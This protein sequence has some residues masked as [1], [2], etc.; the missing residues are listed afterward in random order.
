MGKFLLYIFKIII[1]TFFVA[2]FIQFLAD[3][4]LKKMDDSIYSD[5]NKILGGNINSDLVILGSSR[6]YVSY[7]PIIIENTT[8][9]TS[10]NLSINAGS[11]NLQN[12]KFES[13]L[14]KNR[15]PKVIIQN[16]DLTHFSKSNN[17]PEEFQFLPYLDNKNLTQKL[18]EINSDYSWNH[19]IPLYKYNNYKSFLVK[20]LVSLVGKDY[21][22]LPTNKGFAPKNPLFKKDEHNL[23]RLRAMSLDTSNI[24]SYKEKLAIS[25]E[26][27]HRYNTD[28][29]KIFLV[30][31]P[32]Y[33][34]RLDIIAPI[35]TPVKEDII[36]IVS[37]MPGVYF[38]DFSEDPINLDQK[39]FYDTFHL[40]E[41]GALL[42]TS[43][44][45]KEVD[46]ILKN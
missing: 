23:R 16:I 18:S 37:A 38:L 9:L 43:K 39:Y 3:L 13:Y 30:W 2:L 11:Y 12:L 4:G 28:S 8:G 27:L 15:D 26:F 31:A 5:W 7:D 22:I 29:V 20:G 35:V 24:P 19:Y 44:L 6:G 42:F 33:K 40:N 25:R 45:S 21:S 10:Y 34:E 32:E 41:R 36:Q 14:N 46:S 1:F 17:L